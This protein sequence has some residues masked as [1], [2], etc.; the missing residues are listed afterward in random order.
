MR[1]R[2]E[3]RKGL[4]CGIVLALVAVVFAAVPM[5]V[6]A[7]GEY[8]SYFA[9]GTGTESDPYQISDVDELQ[10]MNLDMNAH[11][12]LVNDIDASDTSTWNS[13]AGF[14]PIGGYFKGSLKGNGYKITDLYID[15]PS[16][17][18]VGLF[19]RLVAY[20]NAEDIILEDVDVTGKWYVGG[21][22]G[23]GY[24]CT[25]S[26]CRSTGSVSGSREIGGLVG[27][28]YRCT[29]SYCSSTS[30]VN[31][32]GSSS[33]D[34]W[35]LGGL[36]GRYNGTMSMCYATG[37]VTGKRFVGGLLGVAERRSYVSNC[38][39]TGSAT[40]QYFVGGFCGNI[41]WSTEISNCYSVGSVT[42]TAATI[43]VGG[44]NPYYPSGKITN[45]FWDT[46]TSGQ[47]SSGSGTGKTTSEMKT[48]TTFTD[49]G[50]NF[51]NIWDIDE[52]VTYPYFREANNPPEADAGGPYEVDEGTEIT[53]DASDSSDPDEDELEYRW[54]FNNDD[55]WDTV[56]STDPTAKYTWY[57][58]YSGTVKVEVYDGED[59]DTDTASVTV[60]NVAPTANAGGPYSGAEGSAITISGSATDPGTDT[61][62]YAWD[63]DDD[64][65]YDDST[66]QNPSWT[67]YDNGVYNIKLKV[68]DDDGG[69]D[70][71]TSSV[72]VNNVAPTADA[73]ADKMGV[74]PSPFTFTGSHTDPGT[75]DTHTY[76]WDFDYDGTTF[77]VDATGNGVSHTWLDDFYGTVALRVTDDDGGW[78]IDTCS[79]TV[80]NVAPTVN[81]GPDQSVAVGEPVNFDGKFEDPGTKDTHTIEWNFGDGT[82]TTGT[83]TPTHEY[84]SIGTYTV[85]L[86]VTD[87]DGGVGSDT[88]K[89][90]VKSIKITIDIKPGSCPNSINLKSQGKV[91][92]AILTTD[93]FDAA[94][95]DPETVMFAGASPV[96][97]TMEDV[98]DDGDKDMVLHFNIQDLDLIQSSTHAMLIGKTWEGYDLKGTDTVNIVPKAK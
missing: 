85:T 86:K 97:V 12:I 22:A 13:G 69:W 45:C 75:L 80:N 78:S 71:D 26:S 10:D 62:S 28:C 77:D 36:V 98:D 16:E 8:S 6:S 11:Y 4:V 48:K 60:N 50:R 51:D 54:D 55:T 56:Y 47:S 73:G 79:V 49:A 57:D 21:L 24:F 94:N 27:N 44:F 2:K 3:I 30:S 76:E 41:T 38:Y 58:D 95:V 17:N 9:G 91:P 96:K 67:W 72:T 52:G 63:L 70:I 61:F 59:T 84:Q 65:F 20:S 81:A 68:T 40:S 87:D 46:Q 92:V 82:T 89:I 83:L 32:I 25:I 7:A 64:G 15:R 43:L 19:G 66:I 53:F 1:E 39:A 34:R 14:D 31:G 42:A 18:F 35:N 90:T 5:N 29:V 88:L 74:E 33:S 23:N 93:D 37:S